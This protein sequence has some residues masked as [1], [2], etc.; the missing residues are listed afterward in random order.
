M[1]HLLTQ[2]KLLWI[3]DLWLIGV[4]IVMGKGMTLLLIGKKHSQRQ[5]LVWL[6]SSGTIA[7]SAIAL[8][9][10]VSASVLLPWLLP[11]ALFWLYILP[12][13]RRTA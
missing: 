5:T 11:S 3:P 7:Y 6:S 13:L 2:H 4:A 1:H 12:T 9:S 8:Q 10:Y